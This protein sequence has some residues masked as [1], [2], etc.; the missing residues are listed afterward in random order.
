MRVKPVEKTWF[1]DAQMG[2]ESNGV[3]RRSQGRGSVRWAGQ[4]KVCASFRRARASDR[5]GGW[6]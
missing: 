4:D 1:A 2:A 6:A 3:E 5:N